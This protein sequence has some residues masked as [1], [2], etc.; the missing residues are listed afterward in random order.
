MNIWKKL[1]TESLLQTKVIKIVERENYNRLDVRTEFSSTKKKRH[2][3]RGREFTL[4]GF[5]LL[6]KTKYKN[7][8][9]LL[10]KELT[11]NTSPELKKTEN[12]QEVYE[13]AL[14]I[15]VMIQIVKLSTLMIQEW[16]LIDVGS[17]ESDIANEW[18]VGRRW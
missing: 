4:C 8:N 6:F 10:S 18:E 1:M 9:D 17:R 3:L 16:G 13:P 15:Q 11:M 2:L 14:Y 5:L 7:K 12:S